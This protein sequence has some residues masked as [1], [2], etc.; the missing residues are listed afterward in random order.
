MIGL[1]L[2]GA[3]SLAPAEAH[4]PHGKYRLESYH[5]H[6]DVRHP[7][8]HCVQRHGVHKKSP[9]PTPYRMPPNTHWVWVPGHWKGPPSNQEWAEG[10]WRIQRKGPR[11]WVPGHWVPR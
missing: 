11:R 3:V 10:S 1:L 9:K 6:S 4:R 5:L 7:G 8:S 2:W